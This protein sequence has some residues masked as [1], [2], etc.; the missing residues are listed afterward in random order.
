[1]SANVDHAGYKVA[2]GVGMRKVVLL[3]MLFMGCDASPPVPTDTADSGDTA[4]V[5]D[6]ARPADTAVPTD[7]DETPDTNETGDSADATPTPVSLP[8]GEA[9]CDGLTEYCDVSI[10]GQIPDT[11][12]P[13][14]D[15]TDCMPLP[16][17]CLNDRTCACLETAG[18]LQGFGE[19]QGDAATGLTV[20]FAYP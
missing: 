9:V 6:T 4:D 7:T 5:V 2:V 1:L 13:T 12:G 20:T 17:A 16:A 8:C 19:C 10:P 14:P 15:F 3:A 11:G 18:T